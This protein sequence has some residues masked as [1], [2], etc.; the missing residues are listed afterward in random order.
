MA[1][2][3]RDAQGEARGK[4]RPSKAKAP[5]KHQRCKQTGATTEERERAPAIASDLRAL[6]DLCDRVLPQGSYSAKSSGSKE[7]LD[8]SPLLLALG[9]LRPALV[10]GRGRAAT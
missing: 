8:V 5:T 2:G 7:L 3:G 9:G 10:D 6:L 4:K 1:D